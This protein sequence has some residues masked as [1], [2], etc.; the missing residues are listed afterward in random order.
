MPTSSSHDISSHMKYRCTSISFFT[1]NITW[2]ILSYV[3]SMPMF[4]HNL[5]MQ[6]RYMPISSPRDISFSREISCTPISFF[7]C[8][9]TWQ[10]LS[11]VYS[12][13]VS[14]H[15]MHVSLHICLFLFTI[16]T[17]HITYLFL[18]HVISLLMWNV[19]RKDREA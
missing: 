14:L 1:C 15:N 7:M 9:V 12:M 13:L 8:N 2:P 5:Y 6:A 11:Y 4:V 17:R 3:I 19:T 18:P 10:I 16:C